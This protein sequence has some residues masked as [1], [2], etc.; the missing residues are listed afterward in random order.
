MIVVQHSKGPMYYELVANISLDGNVGDGHYKIHVHCLN[1]WFCI[2]DLM[3][4]EI[5]PQMLSL[6]ESH[7]QIWK[8]S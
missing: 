4:T 5:L 8:K 3:V 6:S 1:R 7:I 2:E